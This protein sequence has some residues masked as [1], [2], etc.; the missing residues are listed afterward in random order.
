MT[1]L[2]K[3][4]RET[5]EAKGLTYYRIFKD[6][7]LTQAQVESIENCNKAYVFASLVRLLDYLDIEIRIG[8][9]RIN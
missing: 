7:G 8:N 9:V 4:I 3:L 1:E 6:L 2:G 5:R